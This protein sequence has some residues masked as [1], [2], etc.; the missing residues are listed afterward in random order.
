MTKVTIINPEAVLKELSSEEKIALLS[1]D[2]MWHTVAVPRLGVPRVRCSD[3]PNGVRG[4]AWTNGAP[5][6]CFPS[7]TGLGAS[8]DV[9]LVRRIGEALGEECRARGVHCLLGPTTNCQRHPCGGRGFESFSEDPHLCGH[10]ALAW[11]EGVQSKKVMITPKRE[12]L[13]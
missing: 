2:D 5:A 13:E 1:G 10:I 7:S 12:Y 3:G 11:I 9:D 6:S 4:T 8:M